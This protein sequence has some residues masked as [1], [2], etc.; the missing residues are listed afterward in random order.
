M[1]L[2][3]FQLLY[4]ITTCKLYQ[5]YNNIQPPVFAIKHNLRF[6]EKHSNQLNKSC[7]FSKYMDFE[8]KQFTYLRSAKI[9]DSTDINI[10]AQN[11]NIYEVENF[12]LHFFITSSHFF[13]V[14][15]T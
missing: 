8:G 9:E 15:L 11:C 5:W 10:L 13:Q 14:N 2:C 4:S 6:G 3:R 7:C 12:H 1:P